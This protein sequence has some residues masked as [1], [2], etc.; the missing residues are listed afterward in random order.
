MYQTHKHDNSAVHTLHESVG[1]IM[2][3]IRNT[4][5]KLH[6][7][8]SGHCMLVT[9]IM[10]EGTATVTHCLPC[11]SDHHHVSNH[12]LRVSLSC[13]VHTKRWAGVVQILYKWFACFLVPGQPWPGDAVKFYP[14]F[15]SKPSQRL[16]RW[17]N[18]DPTLIH[19]VGFGVPRQPFN[20]PAS[21]IKY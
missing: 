7:R 15:R 8:R 21:A 19:Y 18:S 4:A 11:L 16:R 17:Y 5:A 1:A 14:T 20:K 9:P 2:V 10:T 12:V 13:P 3:W 6:A